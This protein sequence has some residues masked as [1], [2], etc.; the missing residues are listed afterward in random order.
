MRSSLLAFDRI[1][2][3][4]DFKEH[5]LALFQYQFEHNAVYRSYC[6]LININPSDVKE[7][8]DI[9]FLPIQFF[10][11]HM[12]CSSPNTPTNYFES[13]GTSGQIRSKHYVVDYSIYHK[14]FEKGFELF[15]GSIEDYTLIALLPSYLERDHAS[16][17]YMANELIQQTKQPLSGFYLD[18]WDKL[19]ATLDR[20]EE[21]GQKTILLGVTFALLEAAEK[22]SWNLNHT[23]VMETGGMKGMRKE[24][25]R[26]ALHQHLKDR[27]GVHNIHAEY[28]MTELFSQAYSNGDGIFYSPPWMKVL[29]R[30]PEDPFEIQPIG[31]TGGLNIIDLANIDSC[32]FIATQDLGKL[33]KDGSFEVLGRF[34]QAEVRGCNLMVV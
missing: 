19:K 14:S 4:S 31:K 24:W 16:L 13:S 1:S 5:T 6:D 26:T 11:S 12:V 17:V 2:N 29:T 7:I 9:P 3:D 30:A 23:L 22:F 18:E 21:K 15:Y 34:D 28:G 20:L 10:K 33:Y 8:N 25:V 32:A 27:F